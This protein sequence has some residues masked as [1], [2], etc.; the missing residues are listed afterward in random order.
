MAIFLA[1]FVVVEM[2]L[3][4]YDK[5]NQAVQTVVLSYFF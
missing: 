5:N 1:I 3:K 4:V 2:L